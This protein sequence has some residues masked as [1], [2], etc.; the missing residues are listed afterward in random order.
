MR[1]I[2]TSLIL[3]FVVL[4]V[5][6]PICNTEMAKEGSGE[7]TSTYIVTPTVIPMEKERLHMNY[8]VF[9]IHKEKA[10][11]SLLHNSTSR[12]L[13]SLHA[14]KGAYNESGFCETTLVNGN[15]IFITYE[16]KGKL[17]VKAEGT[18][19]FVGG[20]GGCGGIEGGGTFTRHPLQAPAK[21]HFASYAEMKY[22]WKMP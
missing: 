10:E 22:N 12:C 13:G 9:G 5:W 17:G 21:G 7:G 19:T 2:I 16:A 14:V 20:T 15:K 3:V 8:E 4:I 1:R 6:A 18:I 11:D